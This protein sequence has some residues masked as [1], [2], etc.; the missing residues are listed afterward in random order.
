M[1]LISMPYLIIDYGTKYVG[2]FKHKPD[3]VRLFT[4]SNLTIVLTFEYV[5]NSDYSSVKSACKTRIDAKD[6][7]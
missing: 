3:P 1:Y 2:P 5:T 4:K 6:A 7:W